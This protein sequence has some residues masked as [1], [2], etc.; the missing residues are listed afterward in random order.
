VNLNSNVTVVIGYKGMMFSVF[1][2]ILK[3]FVEI[4]V[5]PKSPHICSKKYITDK[6]HYQPT[7]TGILRTQ[8]KQN[9]IVKNNFNVK[10]MILVK[11][12]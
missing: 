5:C 10:T 1:I 6:K 9:N 12:K 4:I 3:E 8:Q 11:A 7:T 2:K